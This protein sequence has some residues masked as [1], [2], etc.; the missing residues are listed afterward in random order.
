MKALLA[1]TIF[2]VLCTIFYL[3]WWIAAF[4]PGE[5]GWLQRTNVNLWLIPSTIFGLLGIIMSIIGMQGHGENKPLF[6]DLWLCIGGI[7][8]YFV[9]LAFT[10]F[11]MK[12]SVTTELFLLT[13]W[14]VLT[15]CAINAGY[16]LDAISKMTGIILIVVAVIAVVVGLICYIFYYMVN[17]T[18]SFILGMIPLILIMALDS[19]FAVLLIKGAG[20]L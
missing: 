15:S 14:I 12:R 11:V 17:P 16:C 2:V 4:S 19:L 3:I 5:E 18:L 13:G 10:W 20:L 8:I 1:G 7:I 6:S 9:L